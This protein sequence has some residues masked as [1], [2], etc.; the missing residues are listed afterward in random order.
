MELCILEDN[1]SYTR[2]YIIF[3]ARFSMTLCI[4]HKTSKSFTV[5]YRCFLS[6]FI[7]CYTTRVFKFLDNP[8]CDQ[9]IHMENVRF[10][11]LPFYMQIYVCNMYVI[12]IFSSNSFPIS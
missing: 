2:L 12:S 4:A 11:F 9:I 1:W 7:I 3:F 10:V 8:W 5:N 6:I